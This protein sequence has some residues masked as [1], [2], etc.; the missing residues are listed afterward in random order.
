VLLVHRIAG[1]TAQIGAADLAADFRIAEIDFV[2]NNLSDAAKIETIIL[3][4]NRLQMLVRQVTSIYLDDDTP[5][6]ID[7]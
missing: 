3:L 5:E 6:Y 2:K 4:T 1:R 7:N